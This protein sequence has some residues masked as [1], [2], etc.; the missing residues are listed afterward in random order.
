[1]PA[2]ST[3]VNEQTGN[4]DC[5]S[6]IHARIP[7]WLDENAVDANGLEDMTKQILRHARNSGL[8][9]IAIPLNVG[10]DFPYLA[11]GQFM[12]YFLQQHGKDILNHRV[13]I[14]LCVTDARMALRLK[15]RWQEEKQN[16]GQNNINVSFCSDV[17]KSQPNGMYVHT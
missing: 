12:A 17:S 2:C 11:L 7:Y 14:H 9:R 1:M 15:K 8:R 5:L 10:C 13:E 16:K 4:L 3:E 6:L